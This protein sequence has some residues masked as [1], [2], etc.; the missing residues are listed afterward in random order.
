MT[1]PTPS[2]IKVGYRPQSTG[3]SVEAD[4]ADFAQLRQLAGWQRWQMAARLIR[5]SR[6]VSLR[7]I[8]KARPDDANRVFAQ[9][10]LGDRWLPM[11][12]PTGESAMWIQDPSEIAGLLQPTFDQLAIPY[13]ITGGVAAIVYG[14]PRTTRDL[15]LVINLPQ[16]SLPPLVAA[17]EAS[18]FYCPPTAV[19]AIQAGREQTLSVTHMAMVLNADLILHANTPFD[20]SKFQRRRLEAL[21]IAGNQSFW[22]A[23][24]EDLI[25][26][27]LLWSKGTDSQKQWRDVLGVLKV[28]GETLDFTYMAQWAVSLGLSEALG[29]AIIEAG[30]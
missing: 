1:T 27:K 28:Q 15:D 10:V 16:Q 3:T 17:L 7:G 29:Q 9:A 24:P 13:Y 4:V 8:Q 20:R 6:A 19:E 25:L 12:T 21:D 26:S 18:G 22:V 30:L 11:L 5:W 23:S 2:S 14:E